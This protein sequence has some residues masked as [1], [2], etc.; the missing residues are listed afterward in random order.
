MYLLNLLPRF[1]FTPLIHFIL[2]RTTTFH[3]VYEALKIY[4]IHS[5]I[6]KHGHVSTLQTTG[7]SQT[8][9]FG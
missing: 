1:K 7:S 4:N 3:I 9:V 8:S 5:I 6:I 2:H